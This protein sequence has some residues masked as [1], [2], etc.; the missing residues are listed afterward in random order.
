MSGALN[1]VLSAGGLFSASS[2]TPRNIAVGAAE[3]IVSDIFLARSRSIGTIIPDVMVEEDHHDALIITE[4]P[5]ET[6]AKI[7]DHAF[8]QPARVRLRFGF[9]NSGVKI[10]VGSL[11]N[12]PVGAIK[13]QLSTFL[14]ASNSLLGG[15]LPTGGSYVDQA[16]QKLIDLQSKREPFTLVT[17]KRRYDNMLLVAL[18]VTTDASSENA[19]LCSAECCEVRLVKTTTVA[20]PSADTQ[21]NPAQTAAPQDAGAKQPQAQ[22]PSVL[23]RIVSGIK[24]LF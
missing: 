15:F 8:K 23:S 19:L 13:N 22:S 18:G 2:S 10:G 11:L 24:S 9:S 4:H 3:N 21:A 1:T 17:G 5:V 6:G 16:Y 20:V 14:P 12:D 7:A